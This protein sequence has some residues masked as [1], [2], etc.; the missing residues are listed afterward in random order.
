MARD[1]IL[2]LWQDMLR[3]HTTTKGRLLTMAVRMEKTNYSHTHTQF[4]KKTMSLAVQDYQ[5]HQQSHGKRV[6]CCTGTKDMD[7]GETS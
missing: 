1:N 3:I 4:G 2:S 7:H 6:K 5:S